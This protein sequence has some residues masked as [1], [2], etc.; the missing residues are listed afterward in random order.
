[1]DNRAW[2]ATSG[3]GRTHNPDSCSAATADLHQPPPSLRA[4]RRLP[5]VT[6]LPLTYN[7]GQLLFPP[8]GIPTFQSLL[9][10][11][12][13][14]KSTLVPDF[15]TEKKSGE[16]SLYKTRWKSKRAFGV[17]F[18]GVVRQCSKRTPGL[19]HWHLSSTVPQTWAV[20]EHACSASVIGHPLARCVSR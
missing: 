9:Y 4:I 6:Q 13:L 19:P 3:A 12:S 17:W 14:F 5:P 11:T 18:A 20:W 7:Q 10:S 16:F 15:L 8:T 2:W 1:M